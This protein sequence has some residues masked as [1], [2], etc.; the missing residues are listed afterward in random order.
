MAKYDGPERS[1]YRQGYMDALRTIAL[2]VWAAGV[3]VST[4]VGYLV[5]R[6][7]W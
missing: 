5:G 7:G 3:V 6:M 4:L 1:A 2:P